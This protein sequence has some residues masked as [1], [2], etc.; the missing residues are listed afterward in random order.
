MPIF[1]TLGVFDDAS[2]SSFFFSLSF[3]CGLFVVV[4]L[5]MYL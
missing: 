1:G 5:G 3:F 2:F 4:A